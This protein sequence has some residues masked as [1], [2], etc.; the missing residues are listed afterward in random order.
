[1]DNT[2][3]FLINRQWTNAFLDQVMATFTSFDVWMPVLFILGLLL[4]WQG[5]FRTRSFVIVALLTI[6]FTDGVITQ[7]GKKLINRPRPA[8]AL[9]D[10]RE[11]SLE[12]THPAFLGV[13][14]SVKI[15]ISQ[16]PVGEVVGRSFPSGHAMNN[17]VIATLAILFF[18]R[19]GCLYLIPAAIVAYSR[20]YCGSHWPSDV[21]VSVFLAIGFCLILACVFSVL[22][23]QLASRWLPKLYARHPA[24]LAS[25]VS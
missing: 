19:W 2:L 8:E 10:V 4:L 24:L 5:G 20:I 1:M 7:F 16:A 15:A 11:V 17:T 22:Y 12:K 13:F 21:I 14:R 23:R 18:G 25:S 9:A 3:L 6:A